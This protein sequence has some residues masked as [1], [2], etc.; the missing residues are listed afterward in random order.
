MTL[1][2]RSLLFAGLFYSFL[3]LCDTFCAD[4]AVPLLSPKAKKI[5]ATQP[6]LFYADDVHY[7]RTLG[8]WTASGHVEFAQEERVLEAEHLVYHEKTNLVIAQGNVRLREKD[9]D[10]L[11]ASYVELTGD[12][13]EG[14]LH[15]VRLLLNDKSRLAASRAKREAG[16]NKTVF[17]Q[18]VYTPCYPCEK[19]PGSSPTWQ[20]KARE[21]YQEKEEG[22]VT[23]LDT[24]I[25]FMGIPLF[26]SPWLRF[27]TRRASGFL[28]PTGIASSILG[29]SVGVPYYWA[30]N[31]QSD[32][33]FTPIVT[34]K[35]GAL[36]GAEYRYQ[37]NQASLKL[38]ASVNQSTSYHVATAAGQT[39]D[40]I[41][42]TRGHVF[43]TYNL[44][45]NQNWRLSLDGKRVSDKTY[46]RTFRELPLMGGKWEF[47]Y[48]ESTFQTE[49]FSPQD[50]LRVKGIYYQGLRDL[51]SA[52]RTPFIAPFIAYQATSQPLWGGSYITVDTNV[53]SLYQKEG[54]Q[55]QRIIMQ[56]DWNLPYLSRWGQMFQ[57][58]GS[59]RGD[60]YHS[61]VTSGVD[62]NV[63]LFEGNKG[64]FFPQGGV[65]TRFPLKMSL[66][67]VEPTL[68]VIAAPYKGTPL[69]IPDLD[70][71]GF[72]FN[73]I[74][75]ASGRR[76]RFPGYDRLDV[77]SRMTYG[78]TLLSPYGGLQNTR[79]FLGQSYS[80]TNPPSD[81]NAF[82]LYRGGSDFVGNL[83]S[84][85]H[86]WVT[87]DYRFRLARVHLRPRF[88]EVF[89]G[90]GPEE[91][92]FGISY[93]QY[94]PRNLAM[95][96][97][98]QDPHVQQLAWSV[99]SRF[100]S[101][102]T[103]GLTQL[104][105][106]EKPGGLLSQGVQAVYQNECL[107]VRAFFGRSYY[108]A[109]GVRPSTTFLVTF[110]LKNFGKAYTRKAS[111]EKLLPNAGSDI[112]KF[113]SPYSPVQ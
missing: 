92:R 82:G 37:W 28:T 62:P 101:S 32:A 89:T 74:T 33:T 108:R 49:R 75:L 7:D 18:G 90:L 68:Q 91:A 27:P 61:R 15:E 96:A 1:L 36:L 81:L 6:T 95:T 44:D 83:Q 71:E 53:T 67:I 94:N 52:R 57:L 25:E 93:V 79:L 3:P 112:R 48:L 47:P 23:A 9:G 50:Y 70:C 60:F 109:V 100:T 40:T 12:L 54:N 38:D 31:D 80:F 69:Q 56:G 105:S 58:F 73:D 87:I 22:R 24:H 43:V 99:S 103:V 4:A 85:P 102:W 21:V 111:Y 64:R 65:E 98:E 46:F 13:K 35:R 88:N 19:N 34:V 110:A 39:Q 20:L 30:I 26:Y 14:M 66:L 113:F 8:I 41:P 84:D 77:G 45:M 51:D 78:M 97:P 63:V 106:L 107:Y 17:Q 2:Q 29:T 11:T 5:D 42:G 76:D 55:Y 10:V 59:L 104:R 72:Q 86:P 16:G